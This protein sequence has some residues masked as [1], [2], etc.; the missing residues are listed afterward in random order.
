[1]ADAPNT[2]RKPEPDADKKAPREQ[3]AEPPKE[4][5]AEDLDKVSGGVA[6]QDLNFTT[7]VNKS[8]PG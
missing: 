1:M 4:M 8:S 6:M 2:E 7:K 3:T 5:S